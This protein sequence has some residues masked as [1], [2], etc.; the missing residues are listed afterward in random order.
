MIAISDGKSVTLTYFMGWL[1]DV[2]T[3]N[4]AHIE[5]IEHIDVI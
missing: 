4:G 2:T 5:H 3:L 1:I